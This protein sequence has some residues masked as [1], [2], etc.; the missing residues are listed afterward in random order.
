MS[1]VTPQPMQCEKGRCRRL[2]SGTVFS[3]WGC[4]LPRR[5]W[6][7][8]HRVH[9]KQFRC[10][11]KGKGPRRVHSEENGKTHQAQ[12]THMT[13]FSSS[14]MLIGNVWTCICFYSSCLASRKYFQPQDSCH[15]FNTD[16]S[17]FLF[18]P[19]LLFFLDRPLYTCCDL[20]LHLLYLL[21]F[22]SSYYLYLFLLTSGKFLCIIF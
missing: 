9:W 21:I 7:V 13:L 10:S 22:I 2:S 4:V 19:F 15:F 18:S 16:T 17:I 20:S 6:V 3:S 12:G 8:H 5:L 1:K 11:G 14:L